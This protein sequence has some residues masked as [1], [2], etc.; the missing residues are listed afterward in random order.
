[1]EDLDRRTKA[2]QI[3]LFRK[4]LPDLSSIEMKHEGAAAFAVIPDTIQE[5]SAR[6]DTFKP[7]AT[8][9]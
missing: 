3:A 6:S 4:A 7:K 1:M 5:V 8:E 9:H 2:A